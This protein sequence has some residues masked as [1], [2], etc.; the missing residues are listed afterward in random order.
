MSNRNN[1][2]TAILI[3]LLLILGAGL[4]YTVYE[5]K[6]LKGDYES[7]L[8]KSTTVE[9][10]YAE[11]ED[12]YDRSLNQLESLEGENAS[13][14][15]LVSA[16][17]EELSEAKAYITSLLANKNATE[18]ELSDARKLI[19][20]LTTQRI[21][22]QNTV[23]SLKE[24]NLALERD[25]I[26]LIQEKGII[27]A[28][29]EEATETVMKL[30]SE[31]VE[32][33]EEKEL[34]SILT[35]RNMTATGIK[36][37]GNGKEVQANKASGTKKLKLCFDL[38]EN[39]IAPEGPTK[40]LVRIIGPD[41]V[42]LSLQS[43]GSGTF[44]DAIT[45][46]DMQYTYEIAPDFSNEGKTVCSYWDQNTEYARGGYQALVYQKGYRIGYTS[47]DLR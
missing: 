45:G 26:V 38:L 33:K 41:G 14:D 25:N 4:G 43:M 37:K 32:M 8:N 5:L 15:S 30:E 1:T 47:F 2:F 3:L 22:L 7:L 13:L 42:T 29:L 44:I 28:D 18:K 34:A 24:Q 6:K 39:K 17:K 31:N 40:L 19:E 35:A 16:K 11:L 10:L 36:V 27:A 21:T 12:E 9:E 23:D 20:Q 46:A